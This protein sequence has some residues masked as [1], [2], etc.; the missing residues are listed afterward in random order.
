VDSG[1]GVAAQ[2]EQ[3][4]RGGVVEVVERGV[5]VA[6]LGGDHALHGRRQARVAGG[7]RVVVVERPP[8]L[9]L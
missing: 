7:E 9:L 1:V 8:L 3:V 6:D 2:V 5:G 4:D